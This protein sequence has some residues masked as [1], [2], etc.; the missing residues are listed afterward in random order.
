MRPH[1]CLKPW[2]EHGREPACPPCTSFPELARHAI[3]LLT[4]VRAPAAVEA[5]LCMLLLLRGRV[6]QHGVHLV[7]LLLGRVHAT[8]RCRLAKHWGLE[9]WRHWTGLG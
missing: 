7:L 4:H 3:L 6:L 8:A 9:A 2:L 1:V 5:A